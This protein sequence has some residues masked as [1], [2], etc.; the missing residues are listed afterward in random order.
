MDWKQGRNES[1][2]HRRNGVSNPRQRSR[3]NCVKRK[4]GCADRILEVFLTDPPLFSLSPKSRFILCAQSSVSLENSRNA[5]FGFATDSG[6][7]SKYD[8]GHV[9]RSFLAAFAAFRYLQ[10][11][12]RLSGVIAVFYLHISARGKSLKI[13]QNDPYRVRSPVNSHGTHA[14]R[15]PSVARRFA[16]GGRVA[17]HGN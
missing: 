13:P 12:S 3:A 1:F 4:R 8:R 14:G 16:F 6:A 5:S 9:G 11:N 10:N 17:L 15:R 7:N 2:K